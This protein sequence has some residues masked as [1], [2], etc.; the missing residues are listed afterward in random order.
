VQGSENTA[1]RYNIRVQ[2]PSPRVD[3]NVD[4]KH[5]AAHRRHAVYA[6]EATG[7]LLVA[8]LLLALTLIRYWHEIHWS[9]R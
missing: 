9:L 4:S 7:L 2:P 1:R 3:P 6:S 5:H 8:A